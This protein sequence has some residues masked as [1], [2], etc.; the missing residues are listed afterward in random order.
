MNMDNVQGLDPT[1]IPQPPFQY[2]APKRVERQACDRC[3]GHK[4]RCTRAPSGRSCVR[5]QR[6]GATCVYSS[7][8]KRSAA[9]K[10]GSNSNNST[11]RNHAS[12]PAGQERPRGRSFIHHI[13]D[14]ADLHPIAYHPQAA[15]MNTGLL[16]PLSRDLET[17]FPVFESALS[18]P[19]IPTA[20]GPGAGTGTGSGPATRSHSSSNTSLMESILADDRQQQPQPQFSLPHGWQHT[21]PDELDFLNEAAPLSPEMSATLDKP[22]QEPTAQRPP[23]VPVDECMRNL[24]HLHLTLYQRSRPSSSSS[25]ISASP[26]LQP[27]QPTEA[28]TTH[29]IESAQSL[30]VILHNLHTHHHEQQLEIY[31]ATA[32]SLLACY[33]QLLLLYNELATS[34]QHAPLHS[35]Q[36]NPRSS[37]S[38]PSLS[39]L[40]AGLKVQLALHLLTRVSH[41][42]RNLLAMSSGAA[43]GV[44]TEDSATRP[45]GRFPPNLATSLSTAAPRGH[46]PGYPGIPISGP[47]ETLLRQVSGYEEFLGAK[48]DEVVGGLMR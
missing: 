42:I 45:S 1:L 11:I 8:V 2:E 6:V 13:H 10:D 16:T 21:F 35:T 4:V 18:A 34:L 28:L 38:P 19:Q 33:I 24:F 46:P 23:L 29:L 44:T 17:A 15:W 41:G 25:S 36:P 47:V 27:V 31:S 48:L 39:A 14:E 26:P 12:P 5:C 7:P 20:L 22:G 3:H 30:L 43:T 40:E 32:L 37:I 9:S